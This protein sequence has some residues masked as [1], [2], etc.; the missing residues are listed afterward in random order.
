M[1]YYI[2]TI[3]LDIN[4]YSLYLILL[5]NIFLSI[6]RFIYNNLFV[7]NKI[8]IPIG[9]LLANYIKIVYIYPNYLI[10]KV[11]SFWNETLDILNN[12]VSNIL[13]D[14]VVIVPLKLIINR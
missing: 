8:K 13:Y 12:R 11:I 10:R 7:E 6:A 5:N 14:L 4:I 9:K 1:I 2:Q 3:G